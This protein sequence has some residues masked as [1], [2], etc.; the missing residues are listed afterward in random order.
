MLKK[1]IVIAVCI[2]CT[3]NFLLAQNRESTANKQVQIV[4]TSFFMPQ[5]NR[6]RRIWIYLPASYANSK[7]KYP[8]MYLQ[9]GQNVF[10][11]KTSFAGEWGVDEAMDTLTMSNMESIIVAIDNGS[12]N[13]LSEYSPYD[14]QIER[15][16]A[17]ASLPPANVKA[18]GNQYVDFIVKTLRPY[19]NKNY[20][21]QKLRK[22]T[23][24]AG[25]SMG[26]LISLYALLKYPK[27]FGG[28]GIF[29]PSFWVSEQ[30]KTDI[31]NKSKKVKGEIYLYAGQQEGGSMVPDL[32]AIFQ[33]L[34]KYSKARLTTV[35]RAEGKH[36]EAS[37]RKEFP[38]F[39]KWL[40]K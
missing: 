38:E 19:I 16:K 27:V 23:F 28:A 26:G 15:G 10:D 4:D 21:T 1:L 29:S 20:R 25:S 31:K 36:N 12:D 5:L 35:I 40:L 2:F 9:D 8:V 14:F 13:R 11:N 18:E 24:I 6:H 37:W 7:K 17:N 32:L 30:L 33:L 22:H 34:N 3:G 39:Y